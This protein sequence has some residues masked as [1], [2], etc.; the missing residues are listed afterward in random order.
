MYATANEMPIQASMLAMMT[1]LEL[2]PK[3]YVTSL[4]VTPVSVAPVFSSI[5]ARTLEDSTGFS[6]MNGT[7]TCGPRAREM[8]ELRNPRLETV[9][10]RNHEKMAKPRAV[11]FLRV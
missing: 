11:V 8:K 4:V 3:T 7:A 10:K 6:R 1:R 9:V 5:V 2:E